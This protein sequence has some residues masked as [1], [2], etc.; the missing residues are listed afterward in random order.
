MDPTIIDMLKF[1]GP[2][3]IGWFVAWQLWQQN[4]KND[5]RY[6]EEKLNDVEAKINLD[7]TMKSLVEFV[8]DK[9]K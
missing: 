6:H 9:L 4:K 8:K 3:G 5:E 2:L 1:S 7:N